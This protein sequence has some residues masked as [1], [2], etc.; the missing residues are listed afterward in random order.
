[1]EEGD[2]WEDAAGE[3]S[4]F[5]DPENPTAT[6]QNCIVDCVRFLYIHGLYCL[7]IDISLPRKNGRQVDKSAFPAW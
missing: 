4:T 6:V 7:Y 3:K 2:S 5:G 1:M